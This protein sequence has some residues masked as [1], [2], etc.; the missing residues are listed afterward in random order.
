MSDRLLRMSGNNGVSDAIYAKRWWTLGTLCVALIVIGVDNTIL[1]VALPSIVRDL[2]ASGSQLQ[3]MVDAYTVVFA[4]LLLTSGSLGDRY[5]R[6]HAL[7]FGLAWFGICSGLASTVSSPTQLIIARGLMGVGGAFIFPTTLSILTNTFRDPSER[8]TAIG[9]WAGVS[10]IGIALGPLA[11]GVLVEQFGWGS[12][13]LVNLPICAVALLLAWRFVPNTSDRDESP[14]DPVAAVCSIV[15]FLFLL[16]GIIEG[17]DKGWSAP[18]VLV[19]LAVGLV[20][21]VAFGLWEWRNPTPMLDVR[22]FRNARFSAASATITLTFFGFYAS[23]FLLTQ[24]FQFILRYSPLKAGVMILPTAA[25]LMTGSPIAPRLASRF[26]TKRV[27]VF[28][29]SLVAAAMA[30]YASNTIMSNVALGLA[31]RLVIGWGF[32]ITS[33]PVTESIMGS[34]PPSRAGVGS[35]VNDTTRQTGGALGVAVIGSIFAARYHATI[36][37]LAFLPPSARAVAHESIG[38]SLQTARTLGGATG[39]R[40]VDVATHAYLASMRVTYTVSVL[41]IVLAMGVAYK[42]LPAWA[43]KPATLPPYADPDAFLIGDSPIE[44]LAV[45]VENAADSL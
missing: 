34:L 25:G 3:L 36:G 33:A 32:G 26:G 23:T 19:S 27:V 12:V 7:M 13:F 17:P 43:P 20:F 21:L 22:F 35:A 15:G 31:V 6:R 4:C 29:L 5:G 38:T 37:S 18:V 40:L 16:Y 1:N 42:F 24:Y 9:I 14:L 41:I 44:G 45:G 30:C 2:N 28:G 11:G 8:A 39:A 10:G